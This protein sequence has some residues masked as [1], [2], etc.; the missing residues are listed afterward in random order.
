LIG[1]VFKYAY[2]QA[3]TRAMKGKLL[4]A[5]DW[6]YLLRMRGMKDICRYL[7]GTDYREAFSA[8][9]H[10]PPDAGSVVAVLYESLFQSYAKL[11]KAVP[12]DSSRLLKNLLLRYD[13]ENLKTIL[14]SIWQGR[15]QHD[16]ISMC[17]EMGRLSTLPMDELMGFREI[18]NALTLLQHTRFY[19]PLR[20]ALPQFNAQG[21]IFP[22]EIAIDT[23]VF[24]SIVDSLK[25]LKGVDRRGMEGLTGKLID[26]VNLC[27]MVRFRHLYGLSPEETIN[28]IL[29]GGRYLVLKTLGILSRAADLPSFLAALPSPCREPLGGAQ[30]WSDIRYGIEKW[31]VHELYRVF[32]GDPFQINLEAAY[33]FLK[34][35][36]VR[37]LDSLISAVS[38]GESPERL[39]VLI[40]LPMKEEVV[41]V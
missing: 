22:L 37:A 30:E 2:A 25:Y 21:S 10:V 38:A 41:R 19:T 3:K 5:D 27:W 8:L 23:A 4:N 29:P 31:F 14:R 11:L 17:Y 26:G 32:H 36:E 7:R 35:M 33:L 1:R 15:S 6:H 13:A 40:V 16:T 28:Y 34:E 24:E 20:H 18:P 39:L 12:A 9:S